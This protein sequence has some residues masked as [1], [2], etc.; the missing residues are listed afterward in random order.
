[1][2]S[3]AYLA[4]QSVSD[5]CR[6]M[7]RKNAKP[8]QLPLAFDR[9][10]YRPDFADWL[11]ENAHIWSAFCREANK[12]WSRGRRH[13]SS[14]TIIEY[15][16]HETALADAGGK[17]KVNNNYAPDMARL[18]SESFPERASFFETRLPANAKRAA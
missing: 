13:Y 4:S 5:I 12:V 7:A 6:S 17:F 11:S 14:R 16:R 3:Q 1:M 15:L 10:K 2:S 8:N 18:Y 9:S